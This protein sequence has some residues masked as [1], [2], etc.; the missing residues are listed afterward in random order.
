[1][2]GVFTIGEL[3]VQALSLGFAQAYLVELPAGLFLVDCGMPHQEQAI[4]RSM[5][6][7]QRNDLKLIFITHAHVD[8]Y[9]SAAALK[10]LTG[11]PVAVHRL[12]AAAMA[13]GKSPIR[14]HRPLLKWLTALLERVNPLEPVQADIVLEDGEALRQVGIPG[15]I[16]HTPGHTP[17]SA[18]LVLEDRTAFLG[19]LI[20][21]N[22][23]P[24]L[25][26]YFIDDGEQLRQSYLRLR[27]LGLKEAYVG[28]GQRSLSGEAL[29]RLID[30]ELET[31]RR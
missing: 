7:I 11:A 18:C 22:G 24:H 19:D 29:I 6:R 20:S 13:A 16:L 3:Y 21:T 25:Q 12:D 17:G 30:A 14:T 28:H 8:H 9:G 4:L 26:R 31:I 1:M 2:A 15:M 10:R 5:R 23:K 27:E